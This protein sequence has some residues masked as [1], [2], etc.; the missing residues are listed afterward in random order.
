MNFN[1]YY[2][3]EKTN[4]KT[5]DKVTSQKLNHIQEGLANTGVKFVYEIENKQDSTINLSISFNDVVFYTYSGVMIFLISNQDNETIIQP[6]VNFGNTNENHYS[7]SFSSTVGV[8][9]DPDELLIKNDKSI[10]IDGGGG[11]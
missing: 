3:Y 9:T 1:G 11:R 8:S 5:N 6:L 2:S 4:W 10:P 7:V